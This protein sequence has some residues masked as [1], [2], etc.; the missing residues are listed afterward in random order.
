MKVLDWQIIVLRVI[1]SNSKFESNSLSA[2]M[3][4]GMRWSSLFVILASLAANA[5]ADLGD[6]IVSEMRAERSQVTV[7]SDGTFDDV[8]AGPSQNGHSTPDFAFW[9][10]TFAL[11]ADVASDAGDSQS[12]ETFTEDRQ[13][14]DPDADNEIRLNILKHIESRRKYYYSGYSMYNVVNIFKRVISCSKACLY[15]CTSIR[16]YK[17]QRPNEMHFCRSN[18]K[19]VL[20]AMRSPKSSLKRKIGSVILVRLR[21]SLSLF[22]DRLFHL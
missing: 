20:M 9:L 18:A 1:T 15:T 3:P 10:L 17:I 16:I 8:D 5:V 11:S 4:S 13:T 22:L 21:Y 6:D 19:L 2:R 14:G 12:D 7:N